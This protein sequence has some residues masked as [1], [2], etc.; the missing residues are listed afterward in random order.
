MFDDES[1]YSFK[2]F[3]LL[4]AEPNL[5]DWIKNNPFLSTSNFITCFLIYLGPYLENNYLSPFM[6]NNVLNYLNLARFNDDEEINNLDCLSKKDKIELINSIIR[7]INSQDNNN[8]IDFY[9]QELYKRTLNRKCLTIPYDNLVL[10]NEHKLLESIKYDQFVLITH[11]EQTTNEEFEKE[12]IPILI[13]DLKYFETINCILY[14]YP[15]QFNN[16]LFFSRYKNVIANFLNI[17]NS[18]LG[19]KS[20]HSYNKRVIN[21]IKEMKGK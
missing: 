18:I 15:Q 6:K 1:Y 19:Y 11:S 14:E 3:E 7:L 5:N 12:I 13:S 20:V 10:Y 17:Q 21:K 9:R 4:L 2:V 16:P 8:Y